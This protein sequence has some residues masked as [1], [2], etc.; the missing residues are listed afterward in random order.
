MYSHRGW[1]DCIGEHLVRHLELLTVHCLISLWSLVFQGCWLLLPLQLIFL[2]S[3]TGQSIS[4]F[5]TSY[6][7]LSMTQQFVSTSFPWFL[8]SSFTPHLFLTL[9]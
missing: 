3:I 4:D 1:G 7:N 8:S 9:V 2:F 5:A 6:F